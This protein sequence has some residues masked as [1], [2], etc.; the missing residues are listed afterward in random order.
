M[1]MK[2]Q[3]HSLRDLDASYMEQHMNKQEFTLRYRTYMTE[4]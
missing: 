3:K 4:L 2:N 1:K